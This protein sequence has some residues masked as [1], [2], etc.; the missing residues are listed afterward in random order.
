[1]SYSE[2]R[3]KEFERRDKRLQNARPMA[4]KK[5]GDK[6]DL[7]HI[8]YVMTWTGLCGGSKIILEHC[9]RLVEKG[10]K[11]SVLSH[12]PKPG[13]FPLNNRVDFIQPAFDEV[14]CEHIPKCDVIV[15]TYWKEVY[16][17]IEQQ[18]APVVYFEQGDSHLFDPAAMDDHTM[19]HIK[20]QLQLAPFV[21]TVSSFAAQNLK[22]GFGIN[23]EV[24]PNAVDNAVFYP[25][26]TLKSKN[27]KPVITAIGPDYIYFKRIPDIISA[28]N[29]LRGKGHD[30][31]FIWITPGAPGADISEPAVVNP[32][33]HFIGDCL[34][35]TDIYVCASL[36]ESFCLP[37]LE[38]M[39]C[40]A[41]VVTTDCGGVNEYVREDENALIIE[42]ENVFDIAGKLELLL[43]DAELRSRLSEGALKTAEEFDWDI[44]SGKLEEYY[45]DISTYQIIAE[46][47]EQNGEQLSGTREASNK[48]EVR[49]INTISLCMIVKNEEKVLARCLDSVKDVVDEIIIVDT[50]SDDKTKA[51]AKKYTDNVYD[52]EWINDFSAARN[53]AFSKATMDY[54]MWLDADDILT[55]ENMIKLKNLKDTLN[56]QT[57]IVTMK[58]L[59]HFDAGGNP[60]HSSTRERL[61]RREKNFL[62]QGAVHECIPLI[63]N[64]VHYDIEVHHKKMEVREG[65]HDRNLKIYEA[66]EKKGKE[67]DP[68]EQYYYA[69][70]L[71]DHGMRIKSAYYFEKFLDGKK[72]WQED[73]IASCFNLAIIY[74]ALGDKSK[75]LPILLKSFEYAP[76]RAEAC[77]EIGYFYKNDGNLDSA[78]AW[79]KLAASLDPPHTLGFIL[80]DYWG[81]I[82][83]IE[84]CVCYYEMGDFVN[85]QKYNEAAAVFKPDSPAVEINRSALKGKIS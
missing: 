34:R 85:A 30:F 46:K 78:L 15:A 76:P 45:R 44:T 2:F 7:L 41:A 75:V 63:G 80:M 67:F 84:C 51:I 53:F 48:S 52:F 14:L 39:T 69:R 82:P 49:P 73:N 43:N 9:N 10:H 71:M 6:K 61:I 32:E 16:E 26:P 59:T 27:K 65:Q 20:K 5:T 19:S 36:F 24:I 68:R 40:G 38:A 79:F 57:D 66:L 12:M 33:Q 35:R 17:C 31:E 50:G 77:C 64:I 29:Q 55:E 72:G 83:N 3:Q 42:K 74:K 21:Y 37:A 81:Y 58:Y 18:I 11:I 1:M 47:A 56:P 60:I 54:Q 70:E 8:V 28:V 13:W 23:A 62:W 22:D 25:D 4:L